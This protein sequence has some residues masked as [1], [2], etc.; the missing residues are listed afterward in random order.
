MRQTQKA[1]KAG[2]ALPKVAVLIPSADHVCADFAMS[3]ATMMS[4]SAA[5]FRMVLMN[6]KSSLITIA[7]NNLVKRALDFGADYALFLDSDMT[8]PQNTLLR[9]VSHKKDVVAATYRK[10][11]APFDLLGKL[12]DTDRSDGVAEA[13]HLPTGC[14]LINAKVLKGLSWPWFFETYDETEF[15]TPYAGEDINFCRK[16][17]ANGFSVWA[18]IPLS[19]A[20]GHI[21]QQT[22]LTT[23]AA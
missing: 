4:S 1:P 22:V 21:G 6:E 3:L 13:E 2:S 12:K 15:A 14:M 18:D 19:H 7:R 16:A 9:L 10:R 5:S 20:M 17:R 11:V 8:F 23:P